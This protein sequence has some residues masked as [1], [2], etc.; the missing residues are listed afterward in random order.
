MAK[1]LIP[2]LRQGIYKMSFGYLARESKE[3]T[4]D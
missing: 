2:G 1:W 3:T 4:K